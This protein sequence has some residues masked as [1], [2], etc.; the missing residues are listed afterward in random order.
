VSARRAM[1]TRDKV[2]ELQRALYR[3]AKA[4][5]ERRFHALYDKVHRRDV[6]WRAWV[7]VAR[8]GGAAGV[9]GVT[10]AAIEEAGVGPFLDDL[11]A[12]LAEGRWRPTPVRRVEIP[13][14]DGRT[15]PLG[16]PTVRDRVV[17]A[18]LKIVLE[19]IF[20]ADF[21][22]SSFGFRPKRSVHH[23][24]N[25]AMDEAWAGRQVV[26][27]AD[28]ASFFDEVDH[29]L[30]LDA[31]GERV[32]DRKVL[33]AIRA[34]L[35]AGVLVGEQLLS[36]DTGTPQGGVISPLLANVYLH[37]LD[38]QWE[39]R[40]RGLGR[41]IRFADDLVIVCRYESQAA[42]ALVVLQEELARLGLRT[43]PAKTGIVNLKHGE[44][45][46]LLGFHHRW[47]AA[48][49]RPGVHFL[50]RWPSRRAMARARTRIRDLTARSQLRRPITAVVDDL[51]RFLTGWRGYF[52]H[53][54]SAASFDALEYFLTERLVLYISKK[55]QRR[56]R[57]FGRR[58]LFGSPNR[59]GL[60]SLAGT[61][62]APRPNRWR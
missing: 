59:L 41:L 40:H 58:V 55:H 42:R 13:K 11:A 27:E 26:V 44:G 49:R 45:F 24:L 53:G 31:L 15:R 50:A 28:I 39:Q 29:D 62:S 30:L 1:A 37:R 17:Q 2:A 56:G 33:K 32:I 52:R 18:A 7:N 54:N 34:L 43:Q 36:S 38:R 3:A 61:V 57:W 46:D 51:N 22:A 48:K 23:A 19:P 8:N 25:T 35:G 21:A 10:I 9:D 6:L 12:E 60:V 16:I 14:P 4:L 20:E 5:P 47:V